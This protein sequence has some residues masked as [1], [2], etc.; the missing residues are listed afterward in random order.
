MANIPWSPQS[1]SGA[2]GNSLDTNNATG[3]AFGRLRTA[4]PLALF[5]SKQVH[6]N[7]P[8][9]FDG[10]A[11]RISS[12]LDTLVLCVRPLSAN[13]DVEG[14]MTWREMY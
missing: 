3:D 11:T 2:G 7:Q 9:L 8:L 1:Q 12:T 14:S 5:D 13:P 6:N 4:Q 10:A